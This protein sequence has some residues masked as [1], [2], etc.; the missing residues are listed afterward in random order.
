MKDTFALPELRE[1]EP[2]EWAFVSATWNGLL[3]GDQR[4]GDPGPPVNP[5]GWCFEQIV[6]LADADE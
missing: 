5:A 2:C 6:R 3:M 4:Q 1:R